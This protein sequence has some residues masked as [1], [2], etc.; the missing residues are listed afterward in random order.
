QRRLDPDRT[1]VGV[2]RTVENRLNDVVKHETGEL[3]TVVQQ[4]AKRLVE[5]GEH[6]ALSGVSRAEGDRGLVGLVDVRLTVDAGTGDR[7]RVNSAGEGSIG[8]TTSLVH[9]SV[10]ERADGVVAE[11]DDVDPLTLRH[12]QRDGRAVLNG[13]QPTLSDER[14]RD[15]AHVNRDEVRTAL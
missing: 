7:E 1:A 4:D 2:N 13:L 12:A 5:V 10:L 14:A 8:S 6:T 11:E 3:L 15:T 9:D